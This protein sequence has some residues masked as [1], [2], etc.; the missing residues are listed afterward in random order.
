VHQAGLR[1]LVPTRRQLASVRRITLDDGPERG[2][3]ALAFCTG[4][5]L[6]FWVMSD[7]S[8][9][10][11]PLWWRGVQL[12]WQAPDG[13]I[14]PA[15]IDREGEGQRGF[16]RAISGFV[17]TGGLDHIRQPANGNPLHGRLPFTPAR[18]T[19]CGESWERAEPILFCEGE[20]VQARL[21][22]ESLLLR[23]RIEAPIGGATLRII[24]EV[25][26]FGSDV[27]PQQ[28]LYHFNLGYPAVAT[29]TTVAL[30]GNVVVGP[31]VM[32]YPA[33]PLPANAR[34]ISGAAA[35]VTVTTPGASADAL[36]MAFIVDARTLPYLQLW[37]DL[38]PSVGVLAI[39]PCTSDRSP[40][41]QSLSTPI[42]SHGERRR[43]EVSFR[44]EGQAPRISFDEE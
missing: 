41:G 30:D 40:D 38:R 8:L 6:D 27:S 44:V 43:Y 11:G 14:N 29:G 36:T 34:Q 16:G 28:M 19:S 23:R 25:E 2:V 3:R 13:F 1:A 42:L 4:G 20:V 18:V 26:N 17:V 21:G 37:H 24:D 12:A 35:S 39:E 7:R 33:T 5:G 15:L 9:D 10:I 32:P 22:G 31:I